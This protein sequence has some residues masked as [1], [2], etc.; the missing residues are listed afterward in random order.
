MTIRE[1]AQELIEMSKHATHEP[2][3]YPGIA[4]ITRRWGNDKHSVITTVKPPEWHENSQMAAIEASCNAEFIVHAR[5]HAPGIARKLIGALDVL[6]RIAEYDE[7]GF[8]ED[9]NAMGKL[10]FDFLASLEKGDADNG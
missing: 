10:A 6:E 2:W 4:V 5:N 1:K 9:Y 7:G 8:E 3:E